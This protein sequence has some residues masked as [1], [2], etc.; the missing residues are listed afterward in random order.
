MGR[1]YEAATVAYKLY[2]R[3]GVPDDEE[4][5]RDLAA[6]LMAYDKQIV[7][8][9]DGLAVQASAQEQE[10]EDQVPGRPLLA[11]AP[12]NLILYGPPGTGKTYATVERAVCLCDG[13]LPPGGREAVA[14]RYRELVARKR[15]IFVTFHQS[16]AY[17]DF[18]E[19][20]RPETGGGE[21]GE[22][23]SSGGF[24]LRP[25]PGV[26]RQIAGLAQDNRGRAISAPSFDRER[27][28]FK[29][30]LGRSGEAEGAGIFRE[31]ISG[32]YVVL[33]WGGEIDWSASEYS[34]FEAIKVRWQEDH[35]GATGHDP[36]IQQLFAIRAVMKI[37]DLVVIS[38]GDKKFRAIGE[39]TGPYEF[40]LGVRQEYNHRRPVR[41]LWHNDQGRPREL[42]Y[43]RGFSQVSALS[44]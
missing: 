40:V 44:A 30:S 22:E 3:G 19:G 27:Q 7:A 9:I 8:P 2:E 14:T 35:P 1:D 25:H 36:N 32:D 6:L 34:D 15:I 5:T 10:D 23:A 20:L 33:G 28:V 24:S 43:G 41:W 37:G 11:V 13:S 29:M 26:F 16:Y 31:A 18:V 38:D 21:N 12:T 42:I 17:E 4:I 39:V